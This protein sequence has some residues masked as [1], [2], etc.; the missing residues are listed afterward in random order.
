MALGL[1]V[2][3]DILT[4]LKAAAANSLH[5]PIR[6][7]PIDLLSWNPPS[8]GDWSG[9]ETVAQTQQVTLFL[10]RDRSHHFLKSSPCLTR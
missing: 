10:L 5:S 1:V 9:Y 6:S 8:W 3:V 2:K 4:R 7:N